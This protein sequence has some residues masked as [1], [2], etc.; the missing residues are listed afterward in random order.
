MDCDMVNMERNLIIENDEFYS[1]SKFNLQNVEIF[2]S[3]FT[4]TIPKFSVSLKLISPYIEKESKTKKEL[5]KYICLRR[6]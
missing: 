2:K 6:N 5:M 3:Y 4:N 1:N